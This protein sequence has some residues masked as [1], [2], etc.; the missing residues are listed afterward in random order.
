[1]KVDLPKINNTRLFS[2]VTGSHMWGMEKDDSDVDVSTAYLMDI[3]GFLRGR[4]PNNHQTHGDVLDES[5]YE[6][7]NS[8]RELKKMNVNHIWMVTSPIVVHEGRWLGR[9]RQ[10]VNENKS[11]EIYYSVF[12]LARNN[13][14]DF[15][16]KGDKYSRL[17]KKKLT[18]IG[19]TLQ[20]GINYFLYEK[21]IY[22]K[23]QIKFREQLDNMIIKLK[24]L[25]ESSSLPN[26]PDP[27]P[28]DKF[29][30]DVRAWQL[31]S[32]YFQMNSWGAA[33]NNW[34]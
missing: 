25:F 30:E 31:R 18:L 34:C 5:R 21:F 24:S 23:I 10:I 12:G 15:I 3:K 6:I 19:R 17:Y 4:R 2:T 28:F 20:F 27:E 33:K 1:M 16:E 22:E 13:I 8:I 26:H 9:L 32:Q 7:A 14:K 11:S 29:L